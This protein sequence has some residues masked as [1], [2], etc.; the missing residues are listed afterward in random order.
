MTIGLILGYAALAI[1][2][3]AEPFAESLVE[4][5]EQLGIST[6]LLVQWLAPLASEAPE[7][8]VAALFAWRLRTNAGLGTLVS[9]KVNQWTLLVGTLP[10]VFVIAGGALVGSAARRPPTRGALPHRGPVGV[11]G[12]GPREPEHQRA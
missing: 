11:R 9:S 5:G 3:C 1:L 7:L 6:F 12:R 8:L 10:L 4:T 2:L